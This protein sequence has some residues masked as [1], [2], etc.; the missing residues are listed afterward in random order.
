[1]YVFM[2]KSTEIEDLNANM[3]VGRQGSE[4]RGKVGKVVSMLLM[5]KTERGENSKLGNRYY[6]EVCLAS[7]TVLHYHDFPSVLTQDFV[8]NFFLG[9]DV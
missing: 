5:F 9:E 1:M 3:A 6:C 4:N 7:N 2:N 8:G